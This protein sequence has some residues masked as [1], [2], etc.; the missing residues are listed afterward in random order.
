MLHSQSG[1]SHFGISQT[2]LPPDPPHTFSHTFT[3]WPF[4]YWPFIHGLQ[5]T[6]APFIQWPFTHWL[7]TSWPFFFHALA[8]QTLALC[9][10]IFFS[11]PLY[12]FFTCR[13]FKIAF[14]LNLKRELYNTNRPSAYI[15]DAAAQKQRNKLKYE[16]L[17]V[18]VGS[19]HHLQCNFQ[20]SAL[21]KISSV[22]PY[23]I[24]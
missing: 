24:K 16:F 1:P 20:L 10:L 18:V 7:S 21:I 22:S 14:K 15:P 13:P 19:R 23:P 2:G 5:N 3:Q 8:L 9:V 12:S 17:K 6:Q 11:Y 4:T